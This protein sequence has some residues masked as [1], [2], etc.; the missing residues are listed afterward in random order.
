MGDV[1]STLSSIEQYEL[2]GK[3][4]TEKELSCDSHVPVESSINKTSFLRSLLVS[5]D[6]IDSY[7]VS[8]ETLKIST[9]SLK[10]LESRI[11]KCKMKCETRDMVIN[12]ILFIIKILMFLCRVGVVLQK[13][14]RENKEI[15]LIDLT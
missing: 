1:L 14:R 12:E 3:A 7:P 10:K 5:S 15:N 13:A 4:N 2:L 8:L 11:G 9:V 6:N